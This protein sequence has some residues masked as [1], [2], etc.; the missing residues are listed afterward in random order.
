MEWLF[1]FVVFVVVAI[2]V[3]KSKLPAKNSV[4]S[5]TAEEVTEALRD[6]LVQPSPFFYCEA[7]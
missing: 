6:H 5:T 3:L 2:L 7:R 4:D 1:L